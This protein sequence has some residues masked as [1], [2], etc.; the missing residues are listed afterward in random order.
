MPH[1]P[2]ATW[3]LWVNKTMLNQIAGYKRNLFLSEFCL[4]Y[5]KIPM[6]ALA[7]T[8]KLKEYGLD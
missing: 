8:S 1:S 4:H 2:Q 5:R 6:Q 7:A 3:N